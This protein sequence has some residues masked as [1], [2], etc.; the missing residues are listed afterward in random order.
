[1]TRNALEIR[2]LSDRDKALASVRGLRMAT[3]GVALLVGWAAAHAE[4]AAKAPTRA[5]AAAVAPGVWIG[6]V[7]FTIDT[8]EN[9]IE[10]GDL[11]PTAAGAALDPGAYDADLRRHATETATIQAQCASGSPCARAVSGEFQSTERSDARRESRW[12]VACPRG[13][14][15]AQSVRFLESL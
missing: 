4:D 8:S 2:L 5:N 7:R 3:L 10:R 12:P 11:E 6:S 1:M 15:E 14:A 13:N 9:H